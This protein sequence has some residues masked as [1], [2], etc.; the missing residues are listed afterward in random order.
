MAICHLLAYSV[1]ADAQPKPDTQAGLRPGLKFHT[2][3]GLAEPEAPLV[4]LAAY[5]CPAQYAEII[6]SGSKL[7]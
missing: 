5:C 7:L 1:K 6:Q 4:C 3:A 2:Q